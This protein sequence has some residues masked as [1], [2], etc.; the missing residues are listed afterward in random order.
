MTMNT[1]HLVFALDHHFISHCGATLASI[2]AN[3]KNSGFVIHLISDDPDKTSLK[4]LGDYIQK[5]NHKYEMYFLDKESARSFKVSDHVTAAT[6]YRLFI[7]DQLK[8]INRVIYLD[9]DVIVAG[10]IDELWETDL[11]GVV[12][13]V[14]KDLNADYFNA[15]VMLLDLDRW[16]TS[17][18]TKLCLDWL[19]VHNETVKFWDQD[20][21]NA[22][23]TGRVKFLP[24]KW[25]FLE[26][27]TSPAAMVARDI[28][29]IHFAGKHKPWNYYCEH[30]LKAE[31][32][33]Y[34][35]STPWKNFRFPEDALLPRIKRF[36]NDIL[37]KLKS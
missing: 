11:E 18:I 15:G 10:R 6:Y 37:L 25:N 7:A 29:I 24:E 16:R 31:Y 30:S 28:R 20:V 1:I 8:D 5:S 34:L 12:A 35:S 19:S 26:T 9:S 27:N 36:A 4:P 17:A 33:K 21:L 2:F 13:G 32:F 3:N 22:V 14:V 23:L